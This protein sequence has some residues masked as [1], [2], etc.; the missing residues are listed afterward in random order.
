MGGIVGLTVRVD[1]ER[2]YRGSCWTNTLPVGLFAVD[3]YHKDRSA[4]HTW[5]WVQKLLENRRHDPRIEAVWGGHNMLAPIE[6]GIVVVDYV[7]STFVTAQGYSS[8]TSVWYAD[9][10]DP[11]LD[12]GRTTKWAELNAA[13][14]LSNVRTFGSNRLRQHVADVRTPFDTVI[15]GD[16]DIITPELLTRLGAIFTLT[17][18]ERACWATWFAETEE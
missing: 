6:Y 16:R 13:G 4:A 12:E 5:A 14:L 10:C 7:T 3:F 2:E 18:A 9:A 17:E 1:A 15:S 8:G 11:D